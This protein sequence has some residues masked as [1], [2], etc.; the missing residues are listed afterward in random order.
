MVTTNNFKRETT[1]KNLLKN[2][3]FPFKTIILIISTAVL[4]LP[5]IIIGI[6]G[7]DRIISKDTVLIKLIFLI[8]TF[9]AML[10]FI[11]CT[12]GYHFQLLRGDELNLRI[13]FEALN[14]SFTAMLISFF[15]LIFVFI[16]FVPFMLNWI[17]VFL[18]TIG[19]ITYLA[20]FRIIKD[21]YHEE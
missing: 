1:M 9:I 12:L 16:N 18:T 19:V 21:K 3:P 13:H 10:G 7:S 5:V 11:Y 14:I 15:I 17:L 20:A 8:P 4:F 6:L 2:F